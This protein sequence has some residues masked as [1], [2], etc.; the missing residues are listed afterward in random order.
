TGCNWTASSGATWITITAGT[1]GS[2]NGTVYYS[3]AANTSTTSRSG[4]LTIAGKAFTVSQAAAVSSCTYSISG[5]TASFGSAGGPGSVPVT[6][7]SGCAWTASSAVS[8]VTIS[9]GSSGTGNG[10]VSY[11]V[12]AN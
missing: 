4:S 8:W 10:T 9:A 6:A 1:S 3:V 2:G 5:T 12:A 7:G 11:S